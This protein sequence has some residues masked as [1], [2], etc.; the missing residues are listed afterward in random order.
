MKI[1][2]KGA[3]CMNNFLGIPAGFKFQ[4]FPF[5]CTT[6]QYI[7]NIKRK[8]HHHTL[9]CIGILRFSKFI[10]NIYGGK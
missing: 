7:V 2:C 1:I 3:K 9:H 6:G 8:F 5:N 4:A 10:V